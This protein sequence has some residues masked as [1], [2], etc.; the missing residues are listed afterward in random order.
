MR[1]IE[2]HAKAGQAPLRVD[3]YLLRGLKPLRVYNSDR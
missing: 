3:G 2:M 1:V